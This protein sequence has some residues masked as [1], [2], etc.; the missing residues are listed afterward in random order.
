M[1]GQKITPLLSDPFGWEWNL[2]GMANE[3]LAPLINIKNL[4]FVQVTLVVV[5]HIYSL[6]VAQGIA[7]RKFPQGRS[8]R[9]QL[10]MLIAIIIFSLLSL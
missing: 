5:G 9:S 8:L 4:W 10:S 7:L 3:T 2:F 1:E 6:W